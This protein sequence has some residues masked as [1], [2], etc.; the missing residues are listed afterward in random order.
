MLNQALSHTKD[1]PKIIGPVRTTR[2]HWPLH[3][4]YVVLIQRHI[5]KEI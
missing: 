3:G 4:G 5:Y 2:R 1:L